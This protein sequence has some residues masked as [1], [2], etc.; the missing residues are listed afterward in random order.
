M[1]QCFFSVTLLFAALLINSGCARTL[2]ARYVETTGFQDDYTQLHE[3]EDG[4]ALL[5]FWQEE[6][7]WKSYKKIILAPVTVVKTP[8]S[9][10]NELTHAELFRLKELLDYR[11]RDALKK[12]YI[13]VRKPGAD[14]IRVEFALTEAQTSSVLLDTFS[15]FYPSARVLSGLKRLLTGTESY[16]GSASI[17]SKITDST[18]GALLMAAVDRRA[19]GK[20]LTG[21]DNSWD[22]VE[23]AFIFW[24]QQLSYD[25]CRKQGREQCQ[26]PE[27]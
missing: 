5:C 8:D 9:G 20:N 17:E 25:L 2:Q 13:L 7:D 27:S 1:H 22:D 23:Q 15:T 12:N 18:T 10:L 14:V 11:L 21:S 19:G 26:A 16:V 6:A 3:G 4:Q 24:A